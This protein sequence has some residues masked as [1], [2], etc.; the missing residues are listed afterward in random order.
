MKWQEL[1][2]VFCVCVFVFVYVCVNM[3]VCLYLFLCVCVCLFIAVCESLQVFEEMEELSYDD[4]PHTCADSQ[5]W[6]SGVC[7]ISQ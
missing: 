6:Q 5:S 7:V 2:T 1:S 3:C 4:C